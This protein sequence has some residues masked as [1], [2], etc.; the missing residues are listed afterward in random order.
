MSFGSPIKPFRYWCQKVL[1]LVYDDSLSYYEVLCKLRDKL[2]EIIETLNNYEDDIKEYVDQQIAGIQNN[3]LD[4]FYKLMNGYQEEFNRDIAELDAKIDQEHEWNVQQ[5]AE[6]LAELSG[7]ISVLSQMVMNQNEATKAWV[8]AKIQELI[9]MI[10]EITSVMVIDPTSGQIVPI[11][12]ALNHVYDFLRCCALTAIEYDT[13]FLTAE[14]YDSYQLTARQYDLY[15]RRY[16]WP[17]NP[18]YMMHSPF[19]GSWTRIQY[20]VYKLASLHQTDSL[21]AQAY[22]DLDLTSENY[23]NRN[24]TA[25]NY[26]WAN[27][28]N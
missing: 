28:L 23:D 10:P 19:D 20:V 9:D 8:S 24:I 14:K 7:Q 11:Q 3:W 15:A 26:S 6:I 21:T 12:D 17:H 1:P 18:L 22:D 2:N 25:Y 16:L 27:P 4:T 5:H 13:L